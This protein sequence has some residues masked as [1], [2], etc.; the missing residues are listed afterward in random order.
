MK[1]GE[2]TGVS[3][4]EGKGVKRL[5]IDNYKLIKFVKQSGNFK[6]GS[7]MAE[8][9]IKKKLERKSPK[10]MFGQFCVELRDEKL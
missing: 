6:N 1:D 10:T 4:G 7:T 8:I 3:F 9:I 5:Q 2:D